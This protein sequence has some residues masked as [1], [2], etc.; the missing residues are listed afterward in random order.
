LKP[1]L[2]TVRQPIYEIGKTA[3]NILLDR[4]NGSK[5]FVPKKIVVE[6]SLIVRDSVSRRA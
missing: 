2:T 4:I 1:S 3:A 5:D 6:G